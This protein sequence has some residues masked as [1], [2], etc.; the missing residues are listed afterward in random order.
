MLEPLLEGACAAPG[1]FDHGL[2]L[3]GRHTVSLAQVGRA[4]GGR[5]AEPQPEGVDPLDVDG[6]QGR[7]ERAGD[8]DRDGDAAS[9]HADHNGIVQ[10]ERYDVLAQHAAGRLPVAKQRLHP[11]DDSH[12]PI[13]ACGWV[14][15]P[16]C[17]RGSVLS[18]A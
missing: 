18:R 1:A 16:S 2:D 4:F 15:R 7:L 5:G 3:L 12:R 8:L 9:G 17:L 11:R 14:D 13:L 10:I 6:G